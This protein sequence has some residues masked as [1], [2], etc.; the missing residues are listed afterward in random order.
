MDGNPLDMRALCV[1]CGAD[2][3][4]CRADKEYCSD[5]CFNVDMARLNREAK[6]EALAKL[7]CV[8]C[9]GPVPVTKRADT[10][11]CSRKCIKLHE[12]AMLREEKHEAVA[13]RRCEQCGGAM[14]VTM[15]RHAKFCSRHCRS[16]ADWA[17]RAK[18]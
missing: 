12:V 14:P 5:R 18:G 2:M 13:D 15:R 3:W 9:G 8:H 16:A 7:R 4:P 1:E 6:Q 10:R 17:R 11:F